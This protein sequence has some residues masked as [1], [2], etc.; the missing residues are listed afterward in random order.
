MPGQR[1]GG[2]YGGSRG[3][4]RGGGP[5]GPRRRRRSLG[6][7]FRSGDWWRRW[8]WKKVFGVLGACCLIVI[9][10]VVGAFF[11]AYESIAVPTEVTAAALSQPSTVYYSNGQQIASFS[12]GGESHVI[13]ATSQIPKVMT[14]A[15]TAAEDRF[16]YSEGGVSITGL[17]RA[18]YEDLK[19]GSYSQGGSTLTEQFVKNYYSG[20]SGAGNEDKNLTD[21]AKQVIVAIKLAHLESKSWIMTNYLNIVPMGPTETGLGAAAQTY[22]N[23]SPQKLDSKLTVPQ[24]A[25]LAAIVNSPGVFNPDP[26]AGEDYTLLVQR[27]QYV[28]FNMYRDNDI[29]LSAFEH[30]SGCTSAGI[31][32]CTTKPKNFPTVRHLHFASD[33]TGAKGYIMSMVGQE[34]GATYGISSAKLDSGGYKITTTIRPALMRGLAQAVKENERLMREGGKALPFYAH[35]GATLVQPGTGDI[36]AFYGGPGENSATTRQEKYC[37]LVEC[38]FNFAEAPAPVG[39]SFKPYVLAT[40]V[41]QD[42]NVQTSTLNGFSPLWI[43][44]D[45]NPQDRA[46]LSQRTKPAIDTGWEHF[47]EASENTG[48][49]GV[50][51]ATAISSD[52]AYE[53][54]A[55]KVGDQNIINTAGSLGVG[56]NPLNA[57]PGRND[58]KGLNN[59]FSLNGSQAGSVQIALGEGPLTTV[60]QADTFATFAA[61]GHYATAHIVAKIKQADGAIV[62]SKVLH[63]TPLSAVQ[64]ADVDYALS[65][66]NQP[67]YPGATGYPNAAWDR[68]VVAK[69]GTLGTGAVASEAWFNG[70][71]P[72]YSLSVAL[73]TNK[74]S[75]DID[76]LGGIAGGLGGTWPAKIWDS[77][78]TKQ[79]ASVPVE[80]LPTPDYTGFVKW[81]QVGNLPKPKPKQAHNHKQPGP[82]N[83]GPT[84]KPHGP[85]R[86]CPGGSSSPPVPTPTT[87]APAPTPSPTCTVSPG[88]PCQSPAPTPGA[89]NGQAVSDSA[90]F[91]AQPADKASASHPSNFLQ[92]VGAFLA[93]LF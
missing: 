20:F 19:G 5:G 68:P 75:Q 62:P 69:T 76:G 84:C 34:L 18:V 45:Y 46:E 9:L 71:I 3:S 74:Q 10:A 26:S 25:M 80:Q 15:M 89:G 42:M 82:P 72:Q 32:N 16:F 50:A 12:N 31:T 36:L 65:F 29:S 79:F 54:L 91:A 59:L 51:Q 56:Q 37:T 78:M 87:S 66:D 23:E 40:A 88:N 4:G 1:A 47:N 6:E 33:A 8:T 11:Y 52:P 43:P 27:W 38:D 48:P 58:L 22:F 60:E 61:D 35:V 83:P 81:N 90:M 41:K 93:G 67:T 7:W 44:P 55:H 85:F 28:L 64:A 21:K 77:F 13:L 14:N 2:G 24:A 30:I 39:S 17:M 86:P 70:A 53:D 57:D 92:A 73:F 63:S 49:I